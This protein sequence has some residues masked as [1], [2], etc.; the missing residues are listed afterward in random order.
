MGCMGD[1]EPPVYN[2]LAQQQERV[3]ATL[4]TGLALAALVFSPLL[5]FEADDR[6][7]RRLWLLM[8]L[9]QSFVVIYATRRQLGFRATAAWSLAML[10]VLS[11]YIA[12]L[13]GPTPGTMA[14]HSMSLLLAA[15]FFGRR[16]TLWMLGACIASVVVAGVLLTNGLVEPW[17]VSFWNPLATIVWLRYA[18]VLTIL[19]GAIALAYMQVVEGLTRTAQLLNET[20]LRERAEREQRELAQAALARAQ[21]QEAL[22]QLAAGIA[23]DLANSVMVASAHAE[24]ICSAPA[25]TPE[26]AQD[27]GHISATLAGTKELIER[28]SA[29]GRSNPQPFAPARLDVPLEWLSK[30]LQRVLPPEI[31]LRTHLASTASIAVDTSRLEQALLNLGLNARDAMPRGGVLDFDVSDCRLEAAVPGWIAEPGQ[32]VRISCRDTGIGMDPATLQHIF[33]PFFTTKPHGRGTGLGLAMVRRLVYDAK[34]FILVESSP[35]HGTQLQ[36]HFP[37]QFAAASAPASKA[38]SSV[39]AE[40]GPEAASPS[41]NAD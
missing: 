19:A 24:F 12:C 2:A 39:P 37:V 15:M 6:T 9:P 35:G 7:D 30:A 26:I 16:G 33:E 23:H 41:L 25:A 28:L 36:L 21:R 38:Q 40:P 27:A 31:T 22:A 29:L 1:G 13:R 10:I 34:G 4:V 17:H 3:V 14:L 32:F 11:A 20:L 8:A 5:W 18:A